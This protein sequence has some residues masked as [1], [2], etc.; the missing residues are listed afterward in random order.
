MLSLAGCTVSLG[1][2][3]ASGSGTPVPVKVLRGS[4]NSTLVEVPIY[5][6]NSG[7]YQF[8]VDTGASIS[9]IDRALA[10]RLNLPRS[11]NRQPVSGV[12]GTEQVVFVHVAKWRMGSVALPSATIAS[13]SLPNDRGGPTIE[14]L[15]GSDQLSQFGKVT[16]DYNASTLTTY[17]PIGG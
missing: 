15:L 4:D 17:P 12:G 6:G 2:P 14:G 7:P 1:N 10:L 11:G 5:V 9:L 8:V 16:L 13:G 3:T